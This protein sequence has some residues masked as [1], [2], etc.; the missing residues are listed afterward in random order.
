MARVRA[1]GR[2]FRLLALAFSGLVAGGRPPEAAGQE[3]GPP[4]R[5]LEASTPAVLPLPSVAPP[6][7]A[8]GKPYP[9]NLPAALRLGNARNL[10]IVLA[11]ERL[12]AAAAQLKGAKVLWLPNII[13]GGDYARHDG[14]FWF[15][16]GQVIGNSKQAMMV[17]AAPQLIFSFAD[18]I[19]SPLAARQTA[20]A[21]QADVQTT[22]ND[23][24]LAVARAYFDLL[25]ARGQLAGALEALRFTDDLM[26]RL[27]R[28]APG[29]APPLEVQRSRVLAAALRQARLQSENNWRTA[30]A[31]LLRVLDLD[32]TLVVE[33]LEP[34][35]IRI[36]LLPLDKPVDDLV[37]VALTNRPELASQQAMVQ[38]TLQLLRQ[39]KVRP[40]V[41]SLLVRGWSTP[42]TGTLAAGYFGG[43]VNGSVGNF[44]F[45]EDWDCQL[46][47]TLQNMG[48]G[49]RALI[50]QRLADNKGAVAQLFL[51]QDRV[52]AEVVQAYSLAQTAEGRTGEAET[53]LRDAQALVREHLAA[54]GQTQ[55]L[56]EGGQI[57][58]VVRPLEVVAAIQMLQQAY[59]DFYGSIADANRAQFQLYR[60]MGNPAQTL[61]G[62]DGGQPNGSPC[63][64][65]A[66]PACAPC[67]PSPLSTPAQDRWRSGPQ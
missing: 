62:Q 19:F 60:A 36:R 63:G 55:R 3:E 48:F 50:K 25:Q 20:R 15:D 58:L 54:L 24:L 39:E 22:A 30:S 40:L 34:S 33:P 46:L 16:T 6:P 18:A 13:L 51:L 32:P 21:R 31:E 57:R 45:R 12:Q 1:C 59:V 44:S 53:E 41:P 26:R 5:R 23:T 56:G 27:E 14:P 43:G 2:V 47:W 65:P 11:S 37:P 38:A 64:E 42:V 28:L 9:I 49:N 4:P 29:L 10:D 67:A 17:G 52:A 61:A 35:H 8:A 66:L 7:A